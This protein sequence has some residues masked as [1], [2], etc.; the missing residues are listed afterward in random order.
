MLELAQLRKANVQ[1]KAMI[2]KGNMYVLSPCSLD[3]GA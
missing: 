3:F 1:L 2:E